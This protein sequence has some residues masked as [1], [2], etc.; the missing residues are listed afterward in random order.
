M[1]EILVAEYV[2]PNTFHGYHRVNHYHIA[3]EIKCFFVDYS[4]ERD[5]KVYRS[6]GKFWLDHY[7]IKT[8]NYKRNHLWTYSYT[9]KNEANEAFKNITSYY[10]DWRCVMKKVT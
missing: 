6:D 8:Y 7:E 4:K 1:K 10:T 9:D 3:T 5:M 2:R